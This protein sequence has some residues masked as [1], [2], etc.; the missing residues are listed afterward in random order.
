MSEDKVIVPTRDE[1]KV[2]DFDSEHTHDLIR[3]AQES[4][5]ADKKLTIRGAIKKY[6]K[7]C[8]WAMILSTSLIMEGY[9]LVIITSFYGQTQFQTRFGTYDAALQKY[10]ISAEW[11]S[12]LS[13]SAVIGQLVGLVINTFAQDRFGCRPTMMFFM[14]WM[15]ITIFIPFFAPSLSVL[16]FGE[17]M[18]GI[19]WG[20][21]Q[22]LSTSYASEV[23]PTV[24]RPYVTAYVCMCWGAGILL[25]SGVVRAVVNVSG[26]LGWRLPFAIQWVWPI[27]LFIAAYLAPESPWNCI[28]RGKHDEARKSLA[29]LRQETPERDQQVESSLAYIVYTTELEKRETEDA[30][31]VDC[32][33][34]TNLRRT[35][36]NCVVWAAQILCGNAILGFSVEF[37]EAAGFTEVQAF[38]LNISL[39]AS[40]IIGGLIC[41][42]LMPRL[43]RATLYMGG[44]AFMFCCLVAIGALGFYSSTQSQLAVGI[45]LVISTLCNMTTIGPVCYPIVAETPS[46][47]LRYKTITIGRFVYN[48][49]GIFSNSV[50]PRMVSATSWNWGAKAGLFYAGTNLLCNIWCWFRLPETKDRTFGEIDLMFDN[51]VPAR[52]FKYTTVDQFAVGVTEKSFVGSVSEKQ[53][54]AAVHEV[55]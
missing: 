28:R 41:W 36:I 4:D 45:L 51:H 53:D 13:N 49:T 26:D 37:L 33:K 42:V 34:G 38:D 44:M 7:A 48:V 10:A 9:D 25:S 5:A 55:M 22:T 1:L 47:R 16:A 24:L 52:K 27:P 23:V 8:F 32:F 54:H 29:R 12:V 17:F 2:L 20:V 46:G 30:R 50:T 6:K 18:C 31:F 14:F 15:V 11:Q 3:Q 19:P 43:G 39:S 35:E 21:F 40:Y